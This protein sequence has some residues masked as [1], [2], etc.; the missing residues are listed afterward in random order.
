MSRFKIKTK[1]E[2]PVAMANE[3]TTAPEVEV[4]V[5]NEPA[6]EEQAPEEKKKLE[7]EICKNGC[8]WIKHVLIVGGVI[9]AVYLIVRWLKN[10]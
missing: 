4:K 10:R 8:P 9:L 1:S 2:E 6:T 7:I 3:E 5:E